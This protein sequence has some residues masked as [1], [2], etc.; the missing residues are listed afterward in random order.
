[1]S[2]PGYLAQPQQRNP[3]QTAGLDH[4]AAA[5]THRVPVAAPTFDLRT[6]T[7]F[8]GLVNAADQRAVA[9]VQVLEQQ[10]Q[11]DAGYLTGRPHRP[12]EHL[13]VTGVVLVVAQSHDPQGR[14]HGA[15]ARGQ[16]RAHQQHL[17]FPP[18]WTGKQ[19]CEGNEQGYNGI[20]PGEQ[21][22]AFS[23][24]WVKPAYPV[25]IFF[26]I[27]RKVQL[28]SQHLPGPRLRRS[29]NRTH[30]PR[31][32]TEGVS[33]R[34]VQP[35]LVSQ[36]RQRQV[37]RQRPSVRGSAVRRLKGRRKAALVSVQR[38]PNAIA[39]KARRCAGRRCRR[40]TANH[41]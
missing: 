16:D 40:P 11:Q 34:V 9:A 19:R 8:Q 28:D 23:E 33:F 24:I 4:V 38:Y 25:F 36:V 7:P 32:S 5:G 37:D 17:G 35:I 14:R 22:W 30:M 29:L 6:A 41:P 18:S 3:A 39:V 2:G 12:I 21:G 13:M 1:M 27:F 20:G 10:H 31:L 26:Y 15:L